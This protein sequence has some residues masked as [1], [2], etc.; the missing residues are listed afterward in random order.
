MNQS[1]YLL[2]GRLEFRRRQGGCSCPRLGGVEPA[3]HPCPNM[4]AL[5]FLNLWVGGR[6]YIGQ[7]LIHL[8][9]C[10]SKQ[11]CRPSSV[12]FPAQ[13]LVTTLVTHAASVHISP[14][15]LRLW[16]L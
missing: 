8:P 4:F 10:M 3:L 7:G 16:G 2:V 15:F 13:R 6:S 9:V 11:P 12:A 14:N 1:W 5:E